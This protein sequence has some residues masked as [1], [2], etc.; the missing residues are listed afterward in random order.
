MRFIHTYEVQILMDTSFL[1]VN[2]IRNIGLNDFGTN[3]LISRHAIFYSPHNISLGSNVRID[4]FCIISGNVTVGSYVHIASHSVL[5]GGVAGIVV[6]DFANL[7]Q[8][9]NVFANSDDYSGESMTNPMVPDRFKKL[10]QERVVIRKHVIIGCGSVVLP[11]V[12]IGEGSAIGA[13]SLVNHD[14]EKWSIYAG[15]PARKV[16]NRSR[17]LLQLE[18][19]LKELSGYE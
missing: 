7:S 2:E 13:L 14:I 11:G 6:Q 1:N 9:V 5:T 4:D 17:E 8:R 10:V 19:E 15:V 3:V 12:E 16:K 18:I